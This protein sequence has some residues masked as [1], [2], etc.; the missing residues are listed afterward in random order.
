MG[1]EMCIRD[2]FQN[3]DRQFHCFSHLRDSSKK[4]TCDRQYWMNWNVSK[5]VEKFDAGV[6]EVWVEGGAPVLTGSTQIR[7]QLPSSLKTSPFFLKGKLRNTHIYIGSG[8]YQVH[9]R[10]TAE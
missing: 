8:Y 7:Y 6:V 4:N 10:T 9:F 5:K 2:R 1:S 3:R